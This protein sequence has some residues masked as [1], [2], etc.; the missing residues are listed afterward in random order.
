MPPTF[1]AFLQNATAVLTSISDTASLDAQVWLAHVTGKSRAWVL[2]HPETQLSDQEFAILDSGLTRLASREP[3]AYLIGHREFYGLD[4]TI[5]PDVLIPRPETEILVERALNWLRAFPK[6]R[7]AIDVGTGSGCIAIT[8]ATHVPDLRVLATDISRE[9]LRVAVKNARRHQVEDQ[10]HF[11]QANLLSPFILPPYPSTGFDMI[12]AN[13]PYIPGAIYKNLE[14][15]RW[16]P[17]IAL[18]GGKDGL[19]AIHPLLPA[20]RR[21]LAPGGSLLFEIEHTQGEIA[22]TLA[23][24]TFP[25]ATIQVWQDFAGRDRVVMIELPA[26]ES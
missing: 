19:K 3:L 20:A 21:L 1:R 17:E 25:A 14:V 7:L 24:K 12:C 11:V 5:T 26:I 10:V 18:H 15:R 4:F 6:R 2:A 13:P 23:Q 9:A 22:Y 8:L 16:E